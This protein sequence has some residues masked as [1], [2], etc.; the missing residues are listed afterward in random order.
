MLNTILDIFDQ[1]WMKDALCAQVDPDL[2]FPEKGGNTRD[3]QKICSQC[4]VQQQ[5]LD[6]ALQHDEQY[7]IWGGTPPKKRSKIKA[8]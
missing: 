1:D 7:G 4:D 6:Y 5:C 8:S 2:W 3:A